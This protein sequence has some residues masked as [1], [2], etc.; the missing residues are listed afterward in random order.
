M[1]TLFVLFFLGLSANAQSY[2][3]TLRTGD[4]SV[5]SAPTLARLPLSGDRALVQYKV[6]SMD[7]HNPF[8]VL[9]INA[10][11]LD[12][13]KPYSLEFETGAVVKQ[14]FSL[15]FKRG[16]GLV[17]SEYNA[18][19]AQYQRIEFMDSNRSGRLGVSHSN[20][21]LTRVSCIQN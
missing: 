17:V 8:T 1:K 9:E 6:Q 7:R 4:G 21:L 19:T 10:R 16:T 12:V 14:S 5:K 13:L 15:H 3:C 11:Y 2:L 18:D 20:G